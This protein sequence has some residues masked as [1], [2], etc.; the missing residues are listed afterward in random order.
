M[1]FGDYSGIGYINGNSSYEHGCKDKVQFRKKEK[2]A[3]RYR[4]V[5]NLALLGGKKSSLDN[6]K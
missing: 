6:G 2:R 5:L 4:N 1:V 3:R